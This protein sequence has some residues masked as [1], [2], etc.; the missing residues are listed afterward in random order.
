MLKGVNLGGWLNMEGYILHSRNIP[1]QKFKK[2]FAKKLG[3]SA[4]RDFE[5]A[6]RDHFIGEDDFQKIAHCGFNCIRLPFHHRLIEKHPYHYDREGVGY[7]DRILRWARRHRLWVILDLH[8]ACGA[9]NHD[10]HSDSLGKAELWQRKEYQNRTLALWEFLADLYKD[11]EE[12][13]GYDLLN[14][15]VVPKMETL[16]TFYQNV[17][18]TIRSVDRQHILFVEGNQWAMELEG[19]K[20]FKDDQLVLSI[21]TY[22]PLEFTFNFIPYLSYPLR[23]P[24]SW[25]QSTMKT[26][27]SNYHKISR[28]RSVPIFVGE[29]G[30]NARGGF[31]GEHQWLKDILSCFREFGFH[32]TYWTYKAVK[33]SVFPD[34]IFSYVENPPWVNRQGPLMGWETYALHWPKR[35]KEMIDSWRTK[36]FR[37]NKEIGL[38][39]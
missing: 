39:A 15:A 21:H 33:N 28:K 6:F 17:I 1:E 23:P 2:D 19:L 18:K 25:N 37:P 30:V 36:H 38:Y 3:S 22:Q 29:F 9:Q 26:L 16:N 7:L 20:E 24:Y 4:L 35:K 5:K 11:R 14:E 27:L 13:A 10:W 8:A 32:W 31:Y 12:V 34:G